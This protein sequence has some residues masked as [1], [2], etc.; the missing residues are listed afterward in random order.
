[1]QKE[2]L[3]A[4]FFYDPLQHS[5]GWYYWQQRIKKRKLQLALAKVGNITIQVALFHKGNEDEEESLE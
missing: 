1:M 4:R 3:Q 5:D 2:R